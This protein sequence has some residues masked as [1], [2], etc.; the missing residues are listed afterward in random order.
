MLWFGFETIDVTH[1]NKCDTISFKEHLIQSNKE[2]KE[3]YIDELLLVPNGNGFP[4]NKFYRK[5]FLNR[6]HLRFE[7]QRI[8]QDEVFNLLVYPHVERAYISP[9]VLYTYYIYEKGNTRSRFIPDRFDIYV[10]IREHF[11]KIKSYWQ[12]NDSRMEDY[13][14]RR[15]WSSLISG[16]VPNMFHPD[17]PWNT[18]QKK[19]ELKRIVSHQF[20]QESLQKIALMTNT[21]SRLYQYAFCHSNVSLLKITYYLYTFL[22]SIKKKL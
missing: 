9:E 21:E 14:Q 1:S 7:N 8:Q 6:Y 11:E 22:R 18:Q 20:T 12:L 3:C 13:L 2:L 10:S 17:C 16:I 19:K 5:D 15:F 4:W